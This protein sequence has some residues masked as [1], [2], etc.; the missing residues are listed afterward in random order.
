[1]KVILTDHV[2]HLGERGDAVSVKPGYARNYLLP[3]GLAYLDTPG[4]RKLFEQQQ[5]GWEAMDLERRSAAEKIAAQLAGVE[6]QFERR[7]GERDV[8]FGS[9]TVVDIARALEERGFELERRRIRLDQ[10]IKS[11]GT[12]KV[13][14]AIHRDIAVSIP[15]HVVRPGDQA[16]DE[17]ALAGG[18]SAVEATVPPAGP[19]GPDLAAD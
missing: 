14:V 10:P 13:E 3:K 11:L 4:N 19:S 5:S 12:S 17:Q 15:V 7:A 8:L 9:V 1:M 2:E 16:E 6:L 18:G